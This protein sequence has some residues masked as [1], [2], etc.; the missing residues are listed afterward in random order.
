MSESGGATL[1]F[2]HLPS[3]ASEIDTILRILFVRKKINLSD[4]FS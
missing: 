3:W 1:L 4:N 2:E